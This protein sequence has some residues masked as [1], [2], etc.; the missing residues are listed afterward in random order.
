MKPN[1]KDFPNWNMPIL[2]YEEAIRF[3]DAVWEWATNFEKALRDTSEK[4]VER[5]KQLG[6]ETKKTVLLNT[7]GE[8]S[9]FLAGFCIGHNK[10]TEEILGK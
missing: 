3:I 6:I 8:R 9:A 1:L 7:R 5:I 2:N 10:R 4:E